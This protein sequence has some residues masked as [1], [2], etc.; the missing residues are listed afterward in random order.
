MAMNSL[1]VSTLK[2]KVT[3]VF[4]KEKVVNFTIMT[5][6]E[7]TTK[8]GEQKAIFSYVPCVAFGHEANIARK[9]EKGDVVSA[10]ASIGTNSYEKDGKKIYSVQVTVESLTVNKKAEASQETTTKKGSFD[11]A[12]SFDDVF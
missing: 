5:V 7:Y 2:G 3:Q 8:E 10:I 12:T 4:A 9:F 11:E 6:K 1:N